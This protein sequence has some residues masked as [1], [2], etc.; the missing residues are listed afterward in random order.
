MDLNNKSTSSVVKADDGNSCGSVVSSTSVGIS[1]RRSSQQ[2]NNITDNTS[3]TPGTISPRVQTPTPFMMSSTSN[4]TPSLRSTP[5]PSF[6]GPSSTPT[7]ATTNPT[8][9]ITSGSNNTP[10]NANSNKIISRNVNGTCKYKLKYF[11][12]R[13]GIEK[14][15]ILKMV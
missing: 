11:I 7:H 13:M 9:S 10:M 4:L 3:A 14:C 12:Y 8:N 6:V 15:A 5:S 2:N 1:L